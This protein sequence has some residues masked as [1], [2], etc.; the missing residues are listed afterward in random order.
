MPPRMRTIEQAITELKAA[1]P[2]CALTK[3]ALRQLIVSGRIPC[4][5]VGSG[6]G[7]YLVSLDTLFDYL[8]G[9]PPGQTESEQTGVI[10]KIC[11]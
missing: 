1:D 7:K 10:R 3:T 5:V 2:K 4:V 11:C 9:K 8:S 6:G